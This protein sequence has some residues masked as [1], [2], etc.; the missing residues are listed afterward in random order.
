MGIGARG[1]AGNG[2]EDGI[3]SRAGSAA[4]AESGLG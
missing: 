1:E 2:I 4:R 3:E